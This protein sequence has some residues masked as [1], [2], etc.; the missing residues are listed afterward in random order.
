MLRK[1]DHVLSSE[2]LDAL[3]KE[4]PSTDEDVEQKMELVLDF[5]LEISVRIGDTNM[6]IG[7]IMDLSTGVV[8]D[9]NRMLDENV[10][11]LVNGKPFAKGE[12]LS[13][14]EYFGIR[15]TSIVKPVDRIEKLREME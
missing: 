10:D 5:P 2:E 7:E 6:S 1:K 4:A 15:I 3:L 14:G 13:M 11:L 12:V 9:L 8:I